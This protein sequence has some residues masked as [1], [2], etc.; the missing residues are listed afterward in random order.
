[1]RAIY[2]DDWGIPHLRADSADELSYLQGRNAA[3]D[4]AWQI[5][6]ERWR[7]EGRL[8]EHIGAAGLD[9]DRFARRAR[10]DDTARKCFAALDPPTQRWIASY[11]EGVNSVLGEST[12]PEFAATGTRPGRWEPWSPLGVFLAQHILFAT[13]PTKLWRAHA[14]GFFD[15][16]PTDGSAATRGRSRGFHL[17]GDPHR[18]LELPGVYQQVRLACPEFDVA[19][20]AFPGVPGV[21]H[22]G[23]AGEVAW[24]VTNAMADYQDVYREELR[25]SDGAGLGPS[26]QG[27]EPVPAHTETILVRGADPVSVEVIETPRGP[28][29]DEG[30]QSA[31]TGPGGF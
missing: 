2:R 20:F 24:A 22:F 15:D 29:I 27:W 12:A 7:S 16:D 25:R 14:T 18:I 4:R 17:A 26:A 31:R 9:W 5:E 11:V 19:G 10:L 13:F 8:A 6:A 21:P 1:M 3:A 23:H 30:T 28:I